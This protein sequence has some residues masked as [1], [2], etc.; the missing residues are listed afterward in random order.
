MNRFTRALET[1]T[2]IAFVLVSLLISSLAQR[3]LGHINSGADVDFYVYYFAAQSV[4][5]NP[6]ANIYEG[7]T[8]ENPELRL[9]SP[10]GSAIT[11]HAKAAGINEVSY[12][13]YP[14]LL[15]DL[16]AP[17]SWIPPHLAAELWR[18]F[19][20]TLVFA[21][22]MLIARMARVPV[23]SFAFA[24]IVLA[25]Y[26]FWPVHEA[27]A[28]GQ[29]SIIL[30]A[31]WAVGVVAYFDDCMIL[32]ATA[33]AFATAL[34]VTPILLLPLFFIWRDRRWIVS[35]AAVS[36]G[37]VG[38]M[39]AVNGRHIV[40]LYPTVMST[41]GGG[42]PAMTNKSIGSFLTWVY[43]GRTFTIDSAHGVMVNP[44]HALSVTAKIVSGVFYLACLF[45][46]WLNRRRID[47][48]SR[49]TT[50]SIFCL[51]AASISP[52]SWR[53]GY[54]IALIPLVILWVKALRTPPR[55]FHG[56]LL[57]L[58]TFTFG[59]IAFDLA[60]QAPLPQPCRIFLAAL[61]ITCSVLFCIDVLF[62]ADSDEKMGA[63]TGRDP[64]IPAASLH[65]EH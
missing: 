18:A 8:E 11:N 55:V 62:H 30:L 28:D 60:A 25:A 22:L 17:F 61:W 37:I 65:I 24:T 34:K 51:V 46:V 38:T 47:R 4:H 16:L 20:L 7:A 41:M 64:A 53:N 45:L 19:N 44:P 13:V 1:K 15:A 5:D 58:T 27:I 43:F 32:S 54:A 33:F 63:G 40:S 48:T 59:S 14:P 9:E 49:A 21:S 3:Y 26:S 42:I 23:L 57:A 12:Y 52:V 35:Y 6:H 2:L 56:V 36:F 10:E 31:L 29:I 50:I 39:V